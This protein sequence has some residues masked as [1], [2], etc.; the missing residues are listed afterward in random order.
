MMS[1]KV[2]GR[3]YVVWLVPPKKKKMTPFCHTSFPQQGKAYP[4]PNNYYIRHSGYVGST[5]G[6]SLMGDAY[7]FHHN[8][9]SPRQPVRY[10]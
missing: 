8:V 1:I 4:V 9:G 6:G 3:T 2:D 7:C 10:S 5:N